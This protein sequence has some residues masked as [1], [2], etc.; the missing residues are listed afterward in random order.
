MRTAIPIHLTDRQLVEATH[1]CARLERHATV[2]LIAHLA[3]LDARPLPDGAP[4]LLRY[5]C[6]RL[7]LSERAAL[8]R[9]DVARM[10]RRYP[11]VLDLLA[12]GSL[13]LA[14]AQFLAPYLT[15]ANH[16][17][18]L[19]AAAGLRPPPRLEDATGP[20]AGWHDSG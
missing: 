18:L 15:M 4:S 9:I 10:A 20:G 6:D 8:E 13:C 1:R 17:A 3:V 12:D 19:G 11:L 7:G 14:A 5:C 2:M 16:R